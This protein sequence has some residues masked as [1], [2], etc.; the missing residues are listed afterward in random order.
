MKEKLLE[1]MPEH[2]AQGIVLDLWFSNALRTHA[3]TDVRTTHLS[4][5]LTLGNARRGAAK[6]EL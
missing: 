6:D 2:H 4:N 1:H 5:Y 3:R